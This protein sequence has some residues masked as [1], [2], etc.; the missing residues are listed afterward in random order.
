[1]GAHSGD[2]VALVVR[3]GLRVVV[4]GV[5]LGSAIALASARWVGPLL[6][7]VSPRDPSTFAVVTVTLVAAAVAASWLP[8][9][10][11]ARVDPSEALRTE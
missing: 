11:A 8:A 3:E 9:R 2:V 6:F 1:M 10:R 7:D 5:V 4:A